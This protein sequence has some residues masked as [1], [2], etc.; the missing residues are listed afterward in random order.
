M[1]IFVFSYQKSGSDINLNCTSH[2]F[3]ISILSYFYLP[4]LMTKVDRYDLSFHLLKVVLELEYSSKKILPEPIEIL[5]N[6]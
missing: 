1:Q 4:A 5:K 2:K 6:R 3:F